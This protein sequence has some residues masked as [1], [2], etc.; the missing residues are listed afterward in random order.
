MINKKRFFLTGLSILAVLILTACGSSSGQEK[1]VVNTEAE[2]NTT[3]GENMGKPDVS[4]ITKLSVWVADEELF[5]ENKEIIEQLFSKDCIY[6]PAEDY[7][8]IN[9]GGW[10]F[11]AYSG[12]EK[13]YTI[14][15]TGPDMMGINKK[16]YKINRQPECK[17]IVEK[18][19]R[20]NGVP[21]IR[22]YDPSEITRLSIW[23]ADEE[24]FTENKELIQQLFDGQCKYKPLEGYEN[25]MEGGLSFTAYGKTDVICYITVV[26]GNLF[27]IKWEDEPGLLWYEVSSNPDYAEI[28]RQIRKENGIE[29]SEESFVP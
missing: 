2:N 16:W 8:N 14:V 28:D 3:A 7:D 18:I 6:E 4:K 5:T 17:D 13:I 10:Q 27:G 19:E 12:E 20:E 1:D 23:V 15:V 9:E 22:R 11:E 26:K 29:V 25:Q 24:K 21:K